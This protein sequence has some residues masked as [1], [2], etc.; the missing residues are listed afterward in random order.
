MTF[1]RGRALPG[2]WTTDHSP[3][4]PSDA[5][6]WRKVGRGVFVV[7]VS[8]TKPFKRV[9]LTNR[10]TVFHTNDLHNS[11][12]IYAGSCVK[13]PS[14]NNHGE[15]DPSTRASWVKQA[16]P[17]CTELVSLCYDYTQFKRPADPKKCVTWLKKFCDSCCMLRD[18]T[19]EKR[20]HTYGWGHLVRAPS[21]RKNLPRILFPI[22]FLQF[23]TKFPNYQLRSSARLLHLIVTIIYRSPK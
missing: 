9:A 3:V 10:H 15:K 6:R 19:S 16:S 8:W 1:A 14:T 5:S 17:Y 11:Q 2:G 4:V 20:N 12:S 7:R 13:I 23:A 18:V 22:S 21:G